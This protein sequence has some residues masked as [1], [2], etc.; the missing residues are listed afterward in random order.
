MEEKKVVLVGRLFTTFLNDNLLFTGEELQELHFE[1]VFP[2]K[3]RREVFDGV[4]KDLDTNPLS[5]ENNFVKITIENLWNEEQKKKLRAAIDSV[6]PFEEKKKR[7]IDFSKAGV[8]AA[9]ARLKKAQEVFEVHEINL[10]DARKL[11]RHW[12]NKK[13]D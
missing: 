5:Y 7:M 3:A 13:G 11:L 6:E 4:I 10:F 9:E 12:E 2:N 1:F 8:L